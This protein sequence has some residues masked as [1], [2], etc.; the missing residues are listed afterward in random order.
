MGCCKVM[1]GYYHHH[2][3][4]RIRTP[5]HLIYS[6][7]NRKGHIPL[8]SMCW[9]LG[10]CGQQATNWSVWMLNYLASWKPQWT[11]PYC[12]ICVE[13]RASKGILTHNNVWN[14]VL[15]LEWGE[16]N[17]IK[18]IKNTHLI[19]FHS[20]HSIHS[21]HSIPNHINSLLWAILPSAASTDV[22]YT[23][24]SNSWRQPSVWGLADY[25]PTSPCSTKQR[26]VCS[27]VQSKPRVSLSPQTT[28]H[29]VM[30]FCIA[31]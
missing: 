14:G 23:C 1:L 5:I 30:Y 2:H 15:R 9:H 12:R 7:G 22:Q 11:L 29:V 28:I 17:G 19:P 21:I 4:H 31:S 26:R 20:F 8:C 3:H 18:H 13:L 6:R 27:N 16:W 24:V 25:T 10:L